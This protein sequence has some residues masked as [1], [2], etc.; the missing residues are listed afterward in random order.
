MK[1]EDQKA[2]EKPI[3]LEMSLISNW[4]WQLAAQKSAKLSY[5][6]FTT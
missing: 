4:A 5:T 2:I 3:N 6:Q 1:W